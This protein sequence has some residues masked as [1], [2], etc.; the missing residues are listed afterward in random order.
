MN[1]IPPNNTTASQ[2]ALQKLQEYYNLV[3]Q[4]HRLNLIGAYKLRFECL[5]QKFSRRF[6]IGL[7]NRIADENRILLF[8]HTRD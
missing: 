4:R 3:H 1:Q 6:L 8:Q 2:S 7:A 5:S